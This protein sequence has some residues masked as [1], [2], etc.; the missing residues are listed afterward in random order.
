MEVW[1]SGCLDGCVFCD[2]HAKV[3]T[4]AS[5]VKTTSMVARVESG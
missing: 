1:K 2:I 5:E 4:R 3:Y